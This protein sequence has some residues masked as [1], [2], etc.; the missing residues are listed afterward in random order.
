MNTWTKVVRSGNCNPPGGQKSKT[1]Y[2]NMVSD[3][4]SSGGGN[5]TRLPDPL[6]NSY[7]DAAN[8]G[9][10]RGVK[11]SAEHANPCNVPSD[12]NEPPMKIITQ[13]YFYKRPDTINAP[14]AT[15]E[16]P[17]TIFVKRQQERDKISTN[18]TALN[19]KI[20][21][22]Q[23]AALEREAS[24]KKLKKMLQ[25][26]AITFKETSKSDSK[27]RK[28]LRKQEEKERELIRNQWKSNLSLAE[29]RNSTR[30]IKALYNNPR[31]RAVNSFFAKLPINLQQ[32]IKKQSLSKAMNEEL[33]IEEYF[34]DLTWLISTTC[35]SNG[36]QSQPDPL[37]G[38]FEGNH[39]DGSPRISDL[40]IADDLIKCV[41]DDFDM[42]LNTPASAKF[43]NTGRR[44][45]ETNFDAL[46][47]KEHRT[48]PNTAIGREFDYYPVIDENKKGIKLPVY[49][50]NPAKRIAFIEVVET[51]LRASSQKFSEVLAFPHP[52]WITTEEEARLRPVLRNIANGINQAN[53]PIREAIISHA[54]AQSKAILDDM[55]FKERKQDYLAY[56]HRLFGL[57]QKSAQENL[58]IKNHIQQYLNE[59]TPEQKISLNGRRLFEFMKTQTDEVSEQYKIERLSEYLS[60]KIRPNQSAT[61]FIAEIEKRA[62]ELKRL[63]KLNNA[64]FE[65][66]AVEKICFGL[67]NN[68]D[69]HNLLMGI[70]LKLSDNAAAITFDKVKEQIENFDIS[71]KM[72]KKA[73]YASRSKPS[74][75][76]KKSFKSAKKNKPAAEANFVKFRKPFKKKKFDKALSAERKPNESAPDDPKKFAKNTNK[77]G[78]FK[79]KKFPY[80]NNKF[81]G[82]H[83]VP[84]R[85]NSTWNCPNCGGNHSKHQCKIT[86][87]LRSG[88]DKEGHNNVAIDES[89]DEPSEY[90]F[91]MNS[92]Y[93]GKITRPRQYVERNGSLVPNGFAESTEGPLEIKIFDPD[94]DCKIIGKVLASDIAAGI[95]EEEANRAAQERLRMR[96]IID[97]SLQSEC[98]DP[99]RCF[100]SGEC[101]C[102]PNLEIYH[103]NGSFLADKSVDT[104]DKHSEIS[105][106]SSL[107]ELIS[108]SSS[109]SSDIS[110][111]SRKKDTLASYIRLLEKRSKEQEEALSHFRSM[112][113]NE[114]MEQELPYIEIR[115]NVDKIEPEFEGNKRADLGAANRG[116]NAGDGPPKMIT[117]RTKNMLLDYW[118]TGRIITCNEC[119]YNSK[120]IG[121]CETCKTTFMRQTDDA[122]SLKCFDTNQPLEFLCEICNRITPWAVAQPCQVTQALWTCGYCNTHNALNAEIICQGCTR[123]SPANEAVMGLWEC[124][125]CNTQFEGRNP[126]WLEKPACKCERNA[127]V[128]AYRIEILGVMENEFDRYYSVFDPIF[129]RK[130]L[131]TKENEIFIRSRTTDILARPCHLFMTSQELDPRKFAILLWMGISHQAIE[132]NKLLNLFNQI[133]AIVERM[134]TSIFV[135][136][137]QRHLA[138]ERKTAEF[139]TQVKHDV[140]Q[141]Y[142]I[143]S[144]IT[145]YAQI[146]DEN[147]IRELGLLHLSITVQSNWNVYWIANNTMANIPWISVGN[148]WICTE[149]R[150][151][152]HPLITACRRCRNTDLTTDLRFSDVRSFNEEYNK[153]VLNYKVSKQFL[154]SSE[155]RH[156]NNSIIS[157][158]KE[159][160]RSIQHISTRCRSC[161]K[162]SVHESTLGIA[163]LI[164]SKIISI[165]INNSNLHICINGKCNSCKRN[166]LHDIVRALQNN[167]ERVILEQDFDWRCED[168]HHHQIPSN[169]AAYGTEMTNLKRRTCN[170][171]IPVRERLIRAENSNAIAFPVIERD[172]TI[173]EAEP[174]EDDNTEPFHRLLED[175]SEEDTKVGPA[176]DGNVRYTNTLLILHAG[177]KKHNTIINVYD[178]IIAGSLFIHEILTKKGNPTFT[179]EN[180]IDQ[181]FRDWL[182]IEED[183]DNIE[184]VELILDICTSALIIDRNHQTPLESLIGSITKQDIQRTD[185]LITKQCLLIARTYQSCRSNN[186]DHPMAREEVCMSEYNKQLAQNLEKY[187]TLRTIRE[188]ND[189]PNVKDLTQFDNIPF[190]TIMTVKR[191][192]L[193]GEKFYLDPICYTD[194][195]ELILSS[196]SHVEI[197]LTTITSTKANGIKEAVSK[198]LYRIIVEGKYFAD[199]EQELTYLQLLINSLEMTNILNAFALEI[200]NQINGLRPDCL[201]SKR[202]RTAIIESLET[203]YEF[204]KQYIGESPGTELLIVQI[205]DETNLTEDRIGSLCEHIAGFATQIE[206]NHSTF[207]EA[208][209]HNVDEATAEYN[210]RGKR[211]RDTK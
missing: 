146:N 36:H 132:Q 73:K 29:I 150:T 123:C 148:A 186:L 71:L 125:A 5:F 164:T 31:E 41:Y 119:W 102:N 167:K 161:R 28:H 14:K 95:D 88:R 178:I 64:T 153:F 179:V 44:S 177:L 106:P 185:A 26:S 141:M 22:D 107:P 2:T 130:I 207:K 166:E 110:S 156:Q 56:N 25:T 50:S 193:E 200:I 91:M 6:R 16:N 53:V 202:L 43:I 206:T 163:E 85:G 191:T 147:E 154:K 3:S 111:S 1:V 47:S 160:C 120:R 24:I 63:G 23:L 201:R 170:Q 114:T 197:D 151:V 194:T 172:A 8:R 80:K 103:P 66:E 83:K 96:R 117:A 18:Q 127:D 105:Y 58:T 136:Q 134:K 60:L 38:I 116:T 171:C 68:S 55:Q 175:E 35:K 208:V 203:Y 113:M 108:I 13:V 77:K 155:D 121:C 72:T 30:N 162:I 39:E 97:L 196:T 189:H 61:E 135:E 81:R 76:F 21:A 27:R 180:N 59:L 9:M 89:K 49:P 46:N 133:E 142:N 128:Q 62:L 129:V 187:L 188:L 42:L 143:D 184:T 181:C 149:C 82:S 199:T 158:V 84:Y 210:I 211:P 159:N 4:R 33:T 137:L 183:G 10:N 87:P 7:L 165:D 45:R 17:K 195:R 112:L 192:L 124:K 118:E 131:S 93:N 70:R 32:V 19:A 15:N 122:E 78:H 92:A 12:A 109:L 176:D 79:P 205:K 144:R 34:G 152:N 20:N 90:I 204:T 52:D 140:Y 168:G 100:N 198:G 139:W 11:Q 173:N 75:G 157:R 190:T 169:A 145:T 138:I 37:D 86:K 69:Y 99:L 98:K 94:D 209:L 54:T 101:G 40:E 104:S 65:E 51:E 67:T 48:G 182:T 174:G 115:K 57:L 126:F 74:G